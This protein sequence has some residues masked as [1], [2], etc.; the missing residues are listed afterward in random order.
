M[1]DMLSNRRLNDIPSNQT[2]VV[3]GVTAAKMHA[4][5]ESLSKRGLCR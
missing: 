5:L 3:K 1:N 2:L 4:I